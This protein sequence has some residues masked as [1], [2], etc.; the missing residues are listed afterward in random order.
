VSTQGNRDAL[1]RLGPTGRRAA[2]FVDEAKQQFDSAQIEV[3]R[4]TAQRKQNLEMLLGEQWSSIR[5]IDLAVIFE[6]DLRK[7]NAPELMTDN[8]MSDLL[9]S[10]VSQMVGAVPVFEGVPTTSEQQDVTKAKYVTKMAPAFWYYLK[11][12]SYFR[13]LL[14]MAGYFNC[15]F[16]KVSW[17]KTMGDVVNG[18]PQGEVS[19]TAI[20]PSDM[21]VDPDAERVMPRRI[22]ESD[23]RWLFHRQRTTLGDLK[24]ALHAPG[25]GKTPTGGNIVWCGLPDIKDIT[26]ADGAS[27]SSAESV[28]SERSAMRTPTHDKDGLLTGMAALS[29][30][31]Y[32]EQPNGTYP[33]GRYCLMMPDNGNHIIEYRECLPDDAVMYGNQLPGLFPFFMVWDEQ[34]P[35]QLAGRSR[36]AA[37]ITHQRAINNVFTEWQDVKRRNLPRTYVDRGMGIDFDAAVNDPRMGLVLPYDG[38]AGGEFPKTDWPPAVSNFAENSMTEI[39]HYTRRAEDR[40]RIHSLANYPRRSITATE[41]VEAMR[42]DQENLAQEAFIVEECAYVPATE[43]VLQTVQRHYGNDRMV[44]FL[45]DRNKMEVSRV[46]ASDLCFKD[47]IITASG[48]S[49]PRNRRLMKAEIMN[50]VSVGFFTGK[51]PEETEKKQRWLADLLQLESSV[52]MGSDELDIKNARAENM[53]LLTGKDVPP[54]QPG[55][56]DLIHIHGP[57]CHFDLLKTPEFRNLD[58]GKQATVLQHLEAHMRLHQLRADEDAAMLREAGVANPGAVLARIALGRVRPG[59][60]GTQQQAPGPVAMRPPPGQPIDQIGPTGVR[61]FQETPGPKVANQVNNFP[62]PVPPQGT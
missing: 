14:M 22:D 19:L 60:P 3:L 52:E 6:R 39:M 45:G 57:L 55:D 44:H 30:L 40:M 32:Y 51:T 38:R 17:N 20:P 61:T 10:R 24:A 13:K 53:E 28:M 37:T 48:S 50:L 56:N 36:T 62:S 46:M 8:V 29:V 21:F 18:R 54:P 4:Y 25:E 49:V 12:V 43:L 7:A 47:V 15:A 42:Y 33:R 58:A 35:G 34:V 2:D 31:G 59:Q 5:D 27:G 26:P 9:V 16:G 23:A 1:M 11:M 41:A